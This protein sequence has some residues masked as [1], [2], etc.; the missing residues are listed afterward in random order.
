VYREYMRDLCDRVAGAQSHNIHKAVGFEPFAPAA[1]FFRIA[2]TAAALRHEGSL[3]ALQPAQVAAAAPAALAVWAGLLLVK[4]GLGYLL[5]AG[6]A[7]YVAHY[8]AARASR[9]A[10]AR[11]AAAA[12]AAAGQQAKK[13][14]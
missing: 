10:A 13:D 6:A 5:K 9:G 1:L 7:A 4:L 14:D 8:D 12:S 3:A 11:R 2:L